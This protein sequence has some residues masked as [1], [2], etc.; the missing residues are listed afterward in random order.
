MRKKSDINNVFMHSNTVIAKLFPP[1]LCFL[2]KSTLID[3]LVTNNTFPFVFLHTSQPSRTTGLMW[4][5]TNG[6]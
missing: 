1:F 2:M 5:P 3:Q 6:V 4:Q